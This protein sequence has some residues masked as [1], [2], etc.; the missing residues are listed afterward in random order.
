M[1]HPWLFLAS[2]TLISFHFFHTTLF[3]LLPLKHCLNVYVLSFKHTSISLPWRHHVFDIRGVDFY[4]N[5]LFMY[6]TVINWYREI[7]IRWQSVCR[8]FEY[9]LFRFDTHSEL[10]SQNKFIKSFDIISAHCSFLCFEMN[11]FK[12]SRQSYIVIIG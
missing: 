8:E 2:H 6:T 10:F 11:P 12:H 4:R 7:D 1:S 9:I 3:I 5:F